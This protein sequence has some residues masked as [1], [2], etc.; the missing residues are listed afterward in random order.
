MPKDWSSEAAGE[1]LRDIGTSWAK[2]AE[3]CVLSVPSAIMSRER[4]LLLNPRHPDIGLINVRPPEE[5]FIHE[6]LR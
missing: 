3:T 2:A 6:W 1:S 4:V 5:V